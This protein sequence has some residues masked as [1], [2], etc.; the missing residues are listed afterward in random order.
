[1]PLAEKRRSHAKGTW[2]E[3]HPSTCEQY[4][5]LDGER[6]DVVR[7]LQGHWTPQMVG[8]FYEGATWGQGRDV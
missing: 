4:S 7:L 6:E 8:D 2:D 5:P 1:M 3:K